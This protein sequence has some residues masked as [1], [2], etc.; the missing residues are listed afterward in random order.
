MNPHIAT[1]G[2][3]GWPPSGVTFPSDHIKAQIPTSSNVSTAGPF[4]LLS[5]GA[6]EPGVLVRDALFHEPC[7]KVS[8]AKNYRE[9]WIAS[10]YEPVHIVLLH[11]S[12]CSFELEEAARLVRGSWPTAKILI[13]RS[14][15]VTL[16][17]ALYDD[18][19]VAPVAEDPVRQAIEDTGCF[20]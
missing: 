4:H 16:D 2:M 8:F 11:N 20:E 1:R 17:D 10:K 5:V 3:P 15:E 7:A 18:R 14:G 12:L 9:L 19:L 6:I 13:I